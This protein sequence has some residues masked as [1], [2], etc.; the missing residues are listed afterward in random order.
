MES[1]I[2]RSSVPG[3]P[4]HTS[5][6]GCN[7]PTRIGR[8]RSSSG[9]IG[10]ADGL[11]SMKVPGLDH[12]IELGGM[13]FLT[14]H[15]RVAAVVAGFDLPT[16]PFDPSGG[17]ERSFLRGRFGGG[18]GDPQAGAGYDLPVA[19][20]GRSAQELG[21]AAFEQIVPGASE[22]SA[23]DWVRV[24]GSHEYL[25]RPV[26]DWSI[27]EAMTTVLSPEGYRFVMDAFGY[28]TPRAFNVADGMQYIL[29]GGRGT[30]RREPPTRAWTRSRGRLHAHSR[31]PAARFCLRHELSRTR[32]VDGAHLLTFANGVVVRRAGGRP[33]GTRSRAPA[34]RG[35]VGRPRYA[36]CSGNARLGRGVSG[37]KA[38]RSG[39]SGHGGMAM[40]RRF[41]L[42][43]D[44]PPRKLFYFGSEPDS[45]AALI[46]SYT[47][48]LHSEPWR[49]FVDGSG[50]AGSPAPA[51][52]V[53]EAE[54]YLDAIH[55]S[56]RD[57]PAPPVPR[58]APGVPIR[59]RWAGQSG[60]QACGPT[61]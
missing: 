20:R 3:R 61:M 33:R 34:A 58:S 52:M 8:S 12:P 28:D 14:S 7:S 43:T 11:R 38:V 23:D 15:P 57:R 6:T 9:P 18:L 30:A 17:A 39:T 42:T 56:V 21:V 24:R 37:S 48:G 32:L 51:R 35:I 59:M 55:P 10:S 13:R 4:G 27:A 5:P 36:G 50:A 44:L 19:E 53:A 60:A 46:A 2:S 41:R 45:P 16:H 49:G 22:L 26:I 25:G 40:A 29:G 47:D 31:R 54:R 1:S